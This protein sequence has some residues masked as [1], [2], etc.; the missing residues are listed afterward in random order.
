[1]GWI[2]IKKFKKKPG[3]EPGTPKIREK[4]L[5][6]NHILKNIIKSNFADI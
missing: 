5:S 4:M 1:M 2:K 6:N 3:I